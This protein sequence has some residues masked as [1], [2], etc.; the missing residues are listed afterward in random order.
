MIK[1][2][3]ILNPRAGRLAAGEAFDAQLAELS[4]DIWQPQNSS[5]VAALVQRA[6]QQRYERIVVGGG[7]GTLNAVLNAL[8]GRF[9]QVQL[10]L[11]PL[12]TAN[13]FARS[14]GMPCELDRAIDALRRGDVRPLDVGSIALH[15]GLASPRYFLNVSVGGFSSIAKDKLDET[16]KDL[17]K[18]LAYIVSAVKALPEL[19][20]YQLRLQIDDQ[21]AVE[22][23][24]YNLAIANAKFAG[25]GIPI[26]PEADVA[27]GLLDV[28]VFATGP[29]PKMAAVATKAWRGNHLE[30]EHV[31]YWRA[32]KARIWSEPPF[33]LNVD[34]EEIGSP[35]AEF[36]VLPQALRFVIGPDLPD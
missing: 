7:D 24:A 18:R 35:P 23:Q 29:L 27:D 21:P 10:G 11:L 1:Q 34:G 6:L 28:V 16:R 31:L 3:I 32:R 20:Q 17:W 15:S 19:T 33:D 30:D 25:G 14:I 8:D 36:E 2:C 5:D 12:G 9:D 4:A 26:A 13:D 22:L